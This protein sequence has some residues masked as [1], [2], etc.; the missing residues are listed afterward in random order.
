MH[1]SYILFFRDVREKFKPDDAA[2]YLKNYF[3]QAQ[4]EYFIRQIERYERPE[5]FPGIISDCE[6]KLKS[7]KLKE[8]LKILDDTI[9]NS[10][11]EERKE[12]L[13]ERMELAKVINNLRRS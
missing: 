10:T 1:E 9:Q 5:I 12:L 13:I 7:R 3:E 6:I 4:I 11:G 2:D 8:D